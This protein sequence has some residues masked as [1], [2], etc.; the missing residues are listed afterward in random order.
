MVYP[1]KGFPYKIF[2]KEFELKLAYLY[3]VKAYVQQRMSNPWL[4]MQFIDRI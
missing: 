3:L 4:I 1:C 2:Y